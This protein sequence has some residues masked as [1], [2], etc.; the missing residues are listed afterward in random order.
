MH[1]LKV[2]ITR[3]VDEH[4]PGFV[5]CT[6]LDATGISHVFV[7]KI[8]IVS[9]SNLWIDSSYP[10]EGEIR[11]TVLERFIGPDGEALVR[12]DTE[13]PDHVESTDAKT[14]FVVAAEKVVSIPDI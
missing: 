10:C 12:V 8:P 9:A 7:E 14:V 4:Q 3:F 2:T 6:L 11:C 1:E 13:L 5:E